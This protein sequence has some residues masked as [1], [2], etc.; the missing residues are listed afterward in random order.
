MRVQL[1]EELELEEVA[2]KK[3]TMVFAIAEFACDCCRT[4]LHL[5]RVDR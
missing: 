1:Q 3:W 4:K 5:R 2:V